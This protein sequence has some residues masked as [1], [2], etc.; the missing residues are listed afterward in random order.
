MK[1]I[2][3]TAKLDTG[4]TVIDRQHRRIVDYI[5][6]LYEAHAQGST[7]EATGRIIDELV[8]YTQTHFAFEETMLEDVGYDL[9]ARHKEDHRQ[10]IAL[11]E[12]LRQRF[13]QHEETAV[14]LNHLMVGW[15]LN[16]ILN[17]DS[18]YAPVVLQGH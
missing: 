15:L 6:R 18:R 2:D 7:R 5:N 1:R 3:W 13:R 12:D 4:I 17:E 11:V 8:D 9:L 14:D 16:H 10:F